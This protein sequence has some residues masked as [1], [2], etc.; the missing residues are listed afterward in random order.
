VEATADE[1]SRLVLWGAAADDKLVERAAV[2]EVEN[3]D[4]DDPTLELPRLLEE[5][6]LKVCA[7]DDVELPLSWLDD[8]EPLLV[9]CGCEVGIAEGFALRY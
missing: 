6:A 1:V 2:T 8:S 3:D 7:E 5:L 4:W 9:P